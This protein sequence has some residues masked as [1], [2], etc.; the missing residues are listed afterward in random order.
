[1]AT[2]LT[3][4]DNGAGEM[5]DVERRG[6]GSRKEGF[7]GS[8]RLL[9]ALLNANCGCPASVQIVADSATGLSRQ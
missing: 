7:R 2:H 9:S 1:M 5:V 6:S 4:P 3:G 8:P